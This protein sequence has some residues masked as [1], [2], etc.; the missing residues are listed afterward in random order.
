ME[1]R[2]LSEC[3][4]ISDWGIVEVEETKDRHI[5]GFSSHYNF[6]VITQKIIDYHYDVETRQG[7]AITDSGIL[8]ALTGKPVYYSPN[9]QIQ[10]QEFMEK[11]NCKLKPVRVE[12][13]NLFYLNAVTQKLLSI[14]TKSMRLLSRFLQ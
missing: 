1:A 11:N 6:Y 2:S 12:R 10:L 8:Y 3:G 7:S 14:N 9:K 13:F 4:V 5:I